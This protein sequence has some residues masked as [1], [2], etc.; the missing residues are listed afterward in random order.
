MSSGEAFKVLS[1]FNFFLLLRVFFE[2]PLFFRVPIRFWEFLFILEPDF[3]PKDALLCYPNDLWSYLKL[4]L[5]GSVLKA[6]SDLSASDFLEP[7]DFLDS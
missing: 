2:E 6:R 1:D 5:L 3:Y 4:Y 7:K